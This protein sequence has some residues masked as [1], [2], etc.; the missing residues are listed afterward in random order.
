[1]R[2]R[3][4]AVS[5][6]A[7]CLTGPG[8]V[9][10]QSLAE[11]EPP[12]DLPPGVTTE[13]VRRG[14]EVFEGEGLCVVCHGA[15]AQGLLGPDLTDD[16]WWHAKGSYVEIV[17]R[18]LR[19]VT[20]EESTSGVSMLPRGGLPLSEIDVQAVA[21]YVWRIS[22][23]ER[24]DSLPLGV[25][26][27]MVAAGYDIFH[28]SESCVRCHGRS[29]TGDTGPNLTDQ[30]WLHAK[31]SF[32]SIVQAILTG[33]PGGRSRSGI[34]MPPRGGSQMNDTDVY[35]VAAYVWSLSRPGGHDAG[36]RD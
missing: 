12:P 28:R 10:G 7:M 34:I 2:A 1:M 5:L 32:L 11:A 19:G 16:D 31:G 17:N 25:N 35:A 3:F 23:P 20:V 13:M 33:F 4:I 15:N 26:T 14:Q 8:V 6:L 36:G 30:E 18:I 29:A 27:E 24:P 9:V 22:H 21:A